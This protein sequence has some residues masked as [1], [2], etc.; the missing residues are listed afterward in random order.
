MRRPN[1]TFG[2]AMGILAVMRL[3]SKSSATTAKSKI[4][5]GP[6]SRQVRRA[7]E[8]REIKN[9]PPAYPS[10]CAEPYED[11]SRKARLGCQMKAGRSTVQGFVV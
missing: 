3:S 8:R 9:T 11:N 7:R 6:E 5:Q 1:I 2:A 4:Q 10:K